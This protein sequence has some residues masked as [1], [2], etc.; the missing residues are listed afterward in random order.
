MYQWNKDFLAN[1]RRVRPKTIFY[2][3]TGDDIHKIVSV[4]VLKHLNQIYKKEI[5]LT[6]SLNDLAL[7]NFFFLKKEDGKSNIPIEEIRKPKEFLNLKSTFGKMLYIQG[8]QDIRVDGYNALL[9]TV[10]D[11]DS[12]TFIWIS[13]ENLKSIPATILSRFDQVKIPSPKTS[14][15]KEYFEQKTIK[16]DDRM[17]TFL[18]QNPNVMMVDDFHLVLRRFDEVLQSKDIASIEKSEFRLFID[19]LIFNNKQGIHLDNKQALKRL[20]LLTEVKKSL[21]SA[22]NLSLDVI[23]LRVTSCLG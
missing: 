12:S 16:F 4:L 5:K 1:P 18:A 6:Q 9:K 10:E 19:Y 7:P 17:L 21:L 3:S 23:R 14:S 20:K 15:I 8:G 2:G 11:S 13:A 22:H